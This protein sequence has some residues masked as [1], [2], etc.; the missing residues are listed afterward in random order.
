MR[1]LV[2]TGEIAGQIPVIADA[3]RRLGHQVTTVITHRNPLYPD[4]DYDVGLSSELIRWPGSIARSGALP[5]R[6]PRY[7]IT[8]AVKLP[9]MLQLIASHDVF[10]FQY[11]SLLPFNR[12]FPLLRKLGK[13]IIT[14][15]VGN[16]ARH[17]SAF[18]QQY[19]FA[20]NSSDVLKEMIEGV[21]EAEPLA[22]PLHNLR[23]AELY[24][25]LILNVPTQ[26]GLALR[27]YMRS[28]VLLEM[29]RYECR[30]PARE[31]PV[32]VHA[33]SLK[34]AK[35]TDVILNA[36]ERL[37][38]EGVA[39]D[40]RLLHGVPNQEVIAELTNA[41]V[42]IDQLYLLYYG[43][44]GAE[45]MACGCA[46]ATS[47]REDCEP[48]PPNRPI[49]HI[50]PANIY[51]QLKHLLT[52][53]ELRIRLA[54]ESRR[55]VERYHD[56]VKLASYF[57]ENL[58]ADPEKRYHFYPTFFARHYRLPEGE[59]IPPYLQRMTAKIVRRWGLPEDVDPRDMIARGLMAAD[60]LASL[61]SVPRWEVPASAESC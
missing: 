10:F 47:N 55:Y 19:G 44:F 59:K 11:Y 52:D 40:L 30:I 28:F 3:F 32:V 54:R 23:M 38:S 51:D 35:G 2:G 37:C 49:W 29:S 46:L 60:S 24:S 57:I 15:F 36:L 16:D 56:H 13:R 43:K 17:S 25:D 39:F 26:S 50:D 33:P 5:V 21:S 58:E 42:A 7:L 9:K 6:I 53:K 1:I 41:D 48:I 14:Y 8:R 4:I 61:N 18:D 31:A 20:F 34:A 22:R 45:A 12:D 27:P